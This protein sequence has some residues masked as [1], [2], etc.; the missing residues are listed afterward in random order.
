MQAV[1]VDDRRHPEETRA[2]H[3]PPPRAVCAHRRVK[4]AARPAVT[5]VDVAR[6]AR[7]SQAAVSRT[8]TPG[9]S[10]SEAMRE[11]V[12]QAAGRL[13]YTPN[14]HARSLI[15]RRS[16]IVG[17]VVAHL[18]NLFYPVVL[19][20]LSLRLQADGHHLMLFVNDTP[21]A[22]G[23]VQQM[24]QYHVDGIVLAASTLSSA[25]ALRCAD[26]GIP[27]VLFNRVPAAGSGPSTGSVRSDNVGGGRAVA[28][29]LA[30]G[31]HRRIA[32]LA[33]SEESSTNLE[34]ERGFL[35][36]LREAGLPL[37]ARAVGDYDAERAAV[38]TR[39]LFADAARRPDALFAASDHM[40]FAAIDVLRHELGMSVPAQV[41]VVGFD[42]VPQAAWPGYRLTTV[43][44]PLDAMIDAT[45]S[46][47]RAQ[48]ARDDESPPRDAQVVLPCRLVVRDS[49]RGAPA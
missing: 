35:D 22:D 13:G 6:L 12:L 9:A 10:V 25:L 1:T 34:R 2:P 14:A 46:L 20:R 47:L 41:S 39:A 36:G 44:Q 48:L 32:Y 45:V 43:E 37:W 31:G 30:R 49:A 27:V 18:R 38:A 29:F 42:D 24:L 28:T 17:L 4:R 7:V 16:R 5:S 11:K 40:A 33:G 3:R 26:A 8:F 19:E 15:T 21:D 23:L